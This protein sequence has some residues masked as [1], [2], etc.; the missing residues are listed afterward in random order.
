MIETS[1]PLK[2]PQA[3]LLPNSA[4]WCWNKSNNQI[5]STECQFYDKIKA[6]GKLISPNP[7]ELLLKNF[8]A[9]SSGDTNERPAGS[10]VMK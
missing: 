7:A 5:I 3:R 10:G 6:L 9:V 4:R 2:P 8:R 1:S